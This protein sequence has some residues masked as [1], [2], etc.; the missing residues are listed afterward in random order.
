MPV[1]KKRRSALVLATGQVTQYSSEL[2]D[3]Y[4]EK[5]IVKSYTILTTG[6][7]SGNR[8]ITLDH[9][10]GTAV[11]FSGSSVV[12]VGTSL[13]KATG[14][15]TVVITGAGSAGNNGT[16]TTGTA[17]A[18]SITFTGAVITEAAGATVTL[19]KQEVITNGNNV[20]ID[21]NTGLMWAR[22]QSTKMGI[23]GDGKMPWADVV[24][25]IFAFCAAANIAV[26]GGYTDWRVANI[27]EINSLV[28]YEATS[29][30]P[31]S[32]A[33]PSFPGTNVGCSTT[34]PNGV[35]NTMQF[36]LYTGLPASTAK[37]TTAYCVLVRG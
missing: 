34:V 17:V 35:T 21:N 23:S 30:F 16:F 14:G 22:Y 26:L 15:E 25:D 29:A 5:G 19:A 36:N 1:Q 12:G 7:Q 31:N 28:D 33:F 9:Y 32:T 37:T 2:D 8:T 20:V 27:F 4:Y 13:F 3:G 6:A 24:Y 18:G 11:S 10:V